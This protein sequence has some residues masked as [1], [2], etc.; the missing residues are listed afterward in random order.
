MIGYAEDT[1]ASLLEGKP[2]Q[3]ACARRSPL[4]LVAIVAVA[5][6]LA[7]EGWG[8]VA[9]AGI[10][11]WGNVGSRMFGRFNDAM[12]TL[13]DAEAGQAF[14]HDP[15]HSDVREAWKNYLEALK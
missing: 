9:A 5:G 4:V 3:L 13:R 2:K 11:V 8:V 7:P 10:W 15:Q 6:A 12:H 14:W 1:G